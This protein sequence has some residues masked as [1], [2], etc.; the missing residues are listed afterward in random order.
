MHQPLLQWHPQREEVARN[1]RTDAGKA[2]S[3][4]PCP[5]HHQQGAGHRHRGPEQ[6]FDIPRTA[7]RNVGQCPEHQ[8][9]QDEENQ[10]AVKQVE[11]LA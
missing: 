11:C 8:H 1:S 4:I 10:H 7:D 6:G 9:R 5:S 3:R 2:T